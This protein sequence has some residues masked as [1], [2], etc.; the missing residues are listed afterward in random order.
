MTVVEVRGWEG[1]EAGSP[2]GLMVALTGPLVPV[3][4]GEGCEWGVVGAVE[5]IVA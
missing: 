2:R 1:G 4:R 5:V 3:V